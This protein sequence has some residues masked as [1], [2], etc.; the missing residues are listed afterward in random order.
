MPAAGEYL[1][2]SLQ[3]CR[4]ID[5]LYCKM[6][7]WCNTRT[8]EIHFWAPSDRDVSRL[9]PYGSIKD[10]LKEKGTSIFED[11][12]VADKCK[13]IKS[14]PITIPINTI[15]DPILEQLRMIV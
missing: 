15:I 2:I 6:D 14:Y 3:P 13:V 7:V 1:T 5:G 11:Y 12:D 4:M 9:A 10:F 8:F